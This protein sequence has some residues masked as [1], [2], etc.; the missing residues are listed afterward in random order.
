MIIMSH[1]N[2]Q[3]SLNKLQMRE[4][5]A[6]KQTQEKK[7]TEKKSQHKRFMSQARIKKTRYKSLYD[8]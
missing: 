4:R 6:N 3:V 7:F 5:E 2:W 1:E 8:E